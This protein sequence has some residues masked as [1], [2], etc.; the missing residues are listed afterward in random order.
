MDL[1]WDGSFLLRRIATLFLQVLVAI[2]FLQIVVFA[3][4]KIF[5]MAGHW[6]YN[7]SY[8]RGRDQEDCSS[9]PDWANSLQDP[10]SKKLI[11]NKGLGEWLKV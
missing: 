11:T 8:S 3:F 9:K 1:T 6:P 2:L 4:K 10:I 7:P 5:Y